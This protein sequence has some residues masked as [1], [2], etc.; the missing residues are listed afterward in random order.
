MMRATRPRGAVILLAALWL[1]V[2][3]MAPRAAMA[4]AGAVQAQAGTANPHGT[5]N[6]PCADCHRADAWRP[7]AIPA[8]YKHAEDRFPLEGAHAQAACTA[9]HTRLDF[10]GVS[11]TCTSCH[12]DIHQGEFGATCARCHSTRSF[13]DATQMRRLHQL[14][15]FPLTGSHMALECDACHSPRAPG[16]H[17][18]VNLPTNCASCH[19]ADYQRSRTPPHASSGFPTTCETCHATTAWS[20]V[21]FDH[22]TTQFPLTGA[23]RAAACTSCHADGVYRGKP[24]TCV[25]CHQADY[26]R[27][28]SP[29]HAAAGFPTTCQTCHT[30][31]AWT[32]APFDHNTTQFALTGAHRATPCA[33]CHADGVYRGKP[34]TCVSCHQS[35]YSQTT[36]PPHGAAGFATTCQSCH[37]TTTW[38]DA[39]FDHNTTQFALTGAHRALTCA[40]CHVDGVYR[41]KPTTCV[42]CHQAKYSQTTTP[43]HAAAGYSTTCETCHNTTTWNDAVFDHATTLFPLT[44]AHRAVNCAACHADGVYRG[45]PTTCVSCHQTKYNQTTSPPHAAAGFPTMCETCHNTTAWPGAVFDHNATMFPLA[46]AHRAVSCAACHADGVYRGKSTACVSCHQT[47]FNRTTNPAHAPAGFPSTC[48]SC[49]TVTAWTPATFNHSAT[50]FPLTGAHSTAVCSACHGDGVYRGKPTT[51]VSCHQTDYAGTTNPNHAAA[52]FP[53]DCASCHTTT[54]WLGATFDHDGKYFPIYSGMHRGQWST[55]AT[56]HTNPANYALFD[57]LSCHG[58]SQTD[59]DHRGRTGYVY[60]SQNCYACHPRGKAG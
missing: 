46:G 7:V 18:F 24:T 40:N 44:G 35:S 42:S 10:T 26:N 45:K 33:S 51:C 53:T 34:T 43:P 14:S 60:A 57:C 4:Q 31:T 36:T 9:C 55:C 2:A 17:A 56:C 16:H 58:K 22:A 39:V 19:M 30:T 1:L 25:S 11:A 48:E 29:P 49:H 15:A 27:S 13:L 28:A 50:A 21:P 6:A 59:N 54:Q 12:R 41:G 37:N 47:D 8:N 23:H 32:G 38:T 20:G 5:F 52:Q 3:A